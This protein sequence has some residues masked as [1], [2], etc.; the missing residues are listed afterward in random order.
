LGSAC[1]VEVSA[2]SCTLSQALAVSY[3]ALHFIVQA[4]TRVKARHQSVT[5]LGSY[6]EQLQDDELGTSR[7]VIQSRVPGTPQTV[8]DAA[9]YILHMPTSSTLL[10]QTDVARCLS[11]WVLAELRA[12]I[13]V[14]KASSQPTLILAT[15]SILPEPG[16]TD[17]SMEAIARLRDLSLFQLAG[18]CEMEMAELLELV[19]TVGDDTGR[20]VVVNQ[21]RCR[22]N[23]VVALCVKYSVY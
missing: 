14:L 16:T 2:Q 1:I 23:A 13:D 5:P 18:T 11:A 9:V 6:H 15:G 7:I 8:Q 17:L 3:P 20:F 12:H 19:N 22:G 4:P 10:L 21:L